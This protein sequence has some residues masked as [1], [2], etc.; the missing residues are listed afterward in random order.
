MAKLKVKDIKYEEFYGRM[1]EIKY[2]EVYI[3][4][5][6]I[7]WLKDLDSIDYKIIWCMPHRVI[8]KHIRKPNDYVFIDCKQSINVKDNRIL[9]YFQPMILPF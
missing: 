7:E 5:T 4:D 6:L 3:I 9:Y 8:L 2:V 1:S